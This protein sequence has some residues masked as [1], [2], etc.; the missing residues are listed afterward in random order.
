MDFWPFIAIWI[1]EDGISAE[2]PIE[3]STIL[4]NSFKSNVSESLLKWIL[5]EFLKDITEE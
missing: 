3:K 5:N 4:S 2:I 1:T